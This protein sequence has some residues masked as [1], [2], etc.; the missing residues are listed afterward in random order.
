MSEEL[1]ENEIFTLTDEEGNEIEFE[2]IGQ[3][4][5]NGEQYFAMI[6]AEDDGENPDV[7][8]YIILKLAKDGDEEI[9][10]TVDD[11]DE[12]D[13]IADYFDDLF[14][15]EIDYDSEN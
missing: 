6:P 5:K 2:L 1:Y 14:S 15:R 4:E 13:D 9:L 11:D 7:C 3:C 12:L 10:V 8:E